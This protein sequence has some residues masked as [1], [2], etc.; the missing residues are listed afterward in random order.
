RRGRSWSASSRW[1]RRPTRTR[2]R[3]SSTRALPTYLPRVGLGVDVHPLTSSRD[4]YLAGLFWPGEA[5]L[6]GHSDGDVA[7]HAI[8]DALL[9]PARPGGLGPNLR[10]AP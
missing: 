3:P 9:S 4:L 7:A 5:G 6:A 10:T 1:P 8:C 2:P